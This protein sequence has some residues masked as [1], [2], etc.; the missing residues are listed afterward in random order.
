[1]L[2]QSWR[3]RATSVFRVRGKEADMR[4]FFGVGEPSG[5]VHGANL[6]RHLRAQNPGIECVGFGGERMAAAGCRLLYPLCE[7]AVVGFVRVFTNLPRFVRLVDQARR[8]F[9][10]QRPDA[11]VLIDYPG[12]NWHLARHAHAQGIPVFYFVPPQIWAWAS[13]RIRKMRHWVDHVLCTLPFEEPWY[14]S[15]GVQAHYVSHPYYDELIG[16]QLNAA[17]VEEQHDR[18][19]TI[20]GL[21][22]GSRNQEVA[23][24]LSTLLDASAFI[25]ARRPDTRFLIAC[26]KEGHR[27]QVQERVRALAL[28]IEVHAGRTAEIVHLAHSCV[29]V[30]G[31]VSLELLHRRKPSVIVYYCNRPGLLGVRLLKNC[32]YITLVNLLTEKELYP[33][34]LQSRFD[35]RE[36]GSHILHWLNDK[37]A[38]AEICTELGAL[39]DR[40]MQPGAC[41][42][43]AAFVM[44][45]LSRRKEQGPRQAA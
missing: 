2:A 9:T 10:E 22:P 26:L 32:R 43:A 13:W 3:D 45:E 39:R 17:F 8:S 29:T 25:H 5:D 37:A 34:Y 42:R 1:L 11:V 12:F 40:V 27:E 36:V 38:Y 31:S 30:S 20:I 28:P 41:E 33:E 4:I 16:Q 24:N 6:I 7:L 21:L 14:Q 23:H 44:E 15:R 35:P 18:P 19:G